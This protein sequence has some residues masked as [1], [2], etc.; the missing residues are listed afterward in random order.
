MATYKQIGTMALRTPDGE[1][2]SAVPIYD[3]VQ[4]STESRLTRSEEKACSD[5]AEILAAKFKQYRDGLSAA[6]IIKEG[7]L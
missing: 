4:A 1:F 6:G 3:E 2:L 5:I 7:L